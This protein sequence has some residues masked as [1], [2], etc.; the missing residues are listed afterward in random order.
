MNMY[1]GSPRRLLSEGLSPE[2]PLFD[3]LIRTASLSDVYFKHAAAV[4]DKE[5][6]VRGLGYNHIESTS[7]RRRVLPR[8][9]KHPY[10]IHAEVAAL[11]ATDRCALEGGILVVIRKTSSNQLAMSKPCPHCESVIKKH[12][13]LYGLRILC[14][15]FYGA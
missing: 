8:P 14:Y 10:T 7:A 5:G 12:M 4:I 1:V 9:R 3:V 13:K 11:R 15:S 6:F 2:S